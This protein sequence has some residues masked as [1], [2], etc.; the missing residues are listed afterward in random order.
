MLIGRKLWL[1]ASMLRCCDPDRSKPTTLHC[2]NT[3]N[4]TSHRTS[5]NPDTTDWT[6]TPGLHMSSNELEETAQMC[7]PHD[8]VT[9][10][11]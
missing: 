2:C 7:G 5:N 6:Q 9:D 10:I 3:R 8:D 4:C 1:K 11:V